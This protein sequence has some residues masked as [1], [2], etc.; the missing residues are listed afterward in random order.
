MHTQWLV[1]VYPELAGHSYCR[2]PRPHHYRGI[3]CYTE[4]ARE[5]FQA[6]AAAG[7]VGYGAHFRSEPEDALEH[8]EPGLAHD[9]T[10]LPLP[11]RRSGKCH[12]MGMQIIGHIVAESGFVV[13]SAA[14]VRRA[15]S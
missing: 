15:L 1:D 6:E 14:L 3:F 11:W 4:A 13:A 9:G 5:V 10:L 2:N 8:G 12:F 7:R